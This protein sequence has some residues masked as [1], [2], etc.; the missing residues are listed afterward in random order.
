MIYDCLIHSIEKL[1]VIL[2]R[3]S[4]LTLM[5]KGQFNNSFLSL[6]GEGRIFLSKGHQA[7]RIHKK[8]EK[9]R[10]KKNF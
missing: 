1:I 7:I 6:I 8:E 2:L 5:E 4:F 3:R 10:P 9:K